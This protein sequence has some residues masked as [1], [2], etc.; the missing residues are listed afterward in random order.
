LAQAIADWRAA[1]HIPAI[2]WALSSMDAPLIAS[3]FD[4]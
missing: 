1:D 4:D 3:G 2:N